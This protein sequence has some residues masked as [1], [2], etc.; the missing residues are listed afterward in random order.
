MVAWGSQEIAGQKG[1][2]DIQERVM[3]TVGFEGRGSFF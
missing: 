3:V 2:S 1:R